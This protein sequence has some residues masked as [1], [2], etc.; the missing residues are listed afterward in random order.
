MMPARTAFPAATS[1][2]S[3]TTVQPARASSRLVTRP[4]PWVVPVMTAISLIGSACEPQQR[5]AHA[6]HTALLQ[7]PAQA[8][9][10]GCKRDDGRAMLKP[11]HLLALVQRSI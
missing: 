2:H 5:L 8:D 1:R 7:L 11:A 10:L 6:D 3:I 9:A 4:M